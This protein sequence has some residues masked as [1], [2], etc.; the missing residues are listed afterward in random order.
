MKEDYLQQR[1]DGFRGITVSEAT[2]RESMRLAYDITLWW[3]L[4][5]DTNELIYKNRNRFSNIESKTDTTARK[6][7]R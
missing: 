4:K 2:E 5:Y 3:N 1:V 7:G 6:V